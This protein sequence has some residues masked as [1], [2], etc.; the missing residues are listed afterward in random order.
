MRFGIF[1]VGA[2]GHLVL[3]ALA[4]GRVRGAE[5]VGIAGREGSTARREELTKLTAAPYTTQ[6]LDLVAFGAQVIVEAAGVAAARQYALDFI[7][8]GCDLIMMSVGCLADDDFRKRV[9]TAS[10]HSGGQIYIPS[11]ALAGL[12]AI[13]AAAVGAIS[14][15]SLTSRKAPS[16]LTGAPYL[17]AKNEDLS[18]L[19]EPKVIFHGN[20]L[21][22]IAGF[23]GNANVAVALGLAVGN[24]RAVQVTIVADPMCKDTIHEV[25]LVGKFG[26][27]S[28]QIR[29]N[30]SGRNGRTSE[31]AAMSALAAVR[32]MCSPIKIG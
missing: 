31:V 16:A 28:T 6:P 10:F 13:Q 12:D 15:V 24:L 7:E 8:A 1:G 21:D 4:L 19:I 5:L 22:A 23:P 26:S 29:S 11:G 18:N 30:R 2:I 32:R 17:V 3:E 14:A 27:L 9:E 20:A 25:A